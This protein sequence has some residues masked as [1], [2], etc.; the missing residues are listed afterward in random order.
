MLPGG[1]APISFGPGRP[2]ALGPVYMV[3]YDA[4]SKSLVFASKSATG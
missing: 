2:Y 1:N 4:P 3:H